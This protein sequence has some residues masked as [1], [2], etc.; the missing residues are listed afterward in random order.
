MNGHN[1]SVAAE[2]PLTLSAVA[3]SERNGSGR[4]DGSDNGSR[5]CARCADPLPAGA[6]SDARYCSNRCRQ[7]ADRAKRAGRPIAAIAP[8]LGRI[9][10]AGAVD[11]RAQNRESLR[12]RAEPRPIARRAIAAVPVDDHAHSPRLCATCTER[13]YLELRPA[14]RARVSAELVARLILRDPYRS[15]WPAVLRFGISYSHAAAIR[16]G[17]RVAARSAS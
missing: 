6:R 9:S 5:R 8:V 13:R 14:P 17:F 1:A 4:A 11:S 10:G 15:V 2:S 3:R 16:A 12:A 7:A